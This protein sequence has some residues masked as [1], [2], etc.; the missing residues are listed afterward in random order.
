MQKAE[1]AR[2]SIEF[3]WRTIKFLQVRFK[4]AGIYCECNSASCV[5][6]PTTLC[7]LLPPQNFAPELYPQTTAVDEDDVCRSTIDRIPRR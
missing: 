6:R 5:L 4:L 7:S 1:R 3:K 2:K